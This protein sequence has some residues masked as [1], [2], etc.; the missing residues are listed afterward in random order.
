MSPKD[1]EF[2]QNCVNSLTYMKR[3]EMFLVLISRNVCFG[4]HMG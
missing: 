3:N 2:A 4:K 1:S